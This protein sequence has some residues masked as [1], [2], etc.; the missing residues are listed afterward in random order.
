MGKS[1]YHTLIPAMLMMVLMLL[2]PLQSMLSM[3]NGGIHLEQQNSPNALHMDIDF[4][5]SDVVIFIDLI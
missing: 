2:T 3:P 5:E 1:S 4:I